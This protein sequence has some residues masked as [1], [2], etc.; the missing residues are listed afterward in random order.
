MDDVPTRVIWAPPTEPLALEATTMVA[1]AVQAMEQLR[2]WA[3]TSELRALPEVQAILTAPDEIRRACILAAAAFEERLADTLLALI[4]RKRAGLSVAD[5]EAILPPL[6]RSS[7]HQQRARAHSRLWLLMGQVAATWSA[8]DDDGRERLRGQLVRVASETGNEELATRLRK[9]AGTG[10]GV[11][12]TLIPANDQACAALQAAIAASPEPDSSRTALIGLL[13]S[14]PA[15]GKAGKKWA[16]AAAAVYEAMNDPVALGAVLLDALLDAPDAVEFEHEAA[17]FRFGTRR[18]QYLEWRNT[19]VASAVPALAGMIA[20]GACDGAALLPR[21]RKL[22]LKA[23]TSVDGVPRSIKLA[24]ACVSALAD[25]GLSASVTEL[26]RID[27]GTRHGSL[28]KQVRTAIGNLATAQGL[29]RDELLERSVEDHGL[30][31]DGTK[32]ASLANGWTAMLATSARTAE[33]SYAGPDGKARKAP[34]TNVKQASADILKAVR[35]DLKAVRETIGN[36]RARLDALLSSG[37]SW[38]LATWRELYLDHPVTGR[39]ARALIWTFRAGDI[40]STGIPVDVPDADGGAAA[41]IAVLASDGELARVPD[42]A[43]VRLWHPVGASADEVRAWRRLLVDRQT[44]QPVKQ[45]FREV[46][47]LAP[48]EEAT[49]DYS[50]RFAG[51]V[52]RQVQARALMKGRGWAP[53]PLAW[54]DDGID[55][56]VARREYPLPGV[57]QTLR[58]EFFFDYTGND[59][60]S[61]DLY[62]Y[63]ASDQVRFFGA[64]TGEAVPLAEVPPLVFTE[65]MRDVD[66]FIGVTSI[67]NDPEWQDHG[68]GRRFGDT[69][70][71]RWGFGELGASAE[72]RRETL[73][74]LV[75]MLAIADRCTLEDRFLVVRGDLR[76]YRIHLGSGNI[77]MSPNDQYLCIVQ[78]RSSQADKVFLPFDDDRVLSLILSKAFL[79]AADTAITDPTITRQIGTT[80]SHLR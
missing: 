50:N 6:A 40:E 30:A 32:A 71:Q 59:D 80:S 66:L 19:P 56:G 34:P 29:S 57:A 73:A 74:R 58:A 51:H 1:A 76:T 24:N 79:L 10:E 15:S 21:L 3:P 26:L 67:G 72:V 70:W 27:R 46:Y 13:T 4:A 68:E 64:A 7:D 33:I 35:Q 53:V 16:A 9:I 60:M 42:G 14:F 38:E 28:L 2:R 55:Q 31:A 18:G 49:R 39:A 23:I 75:P 77:L 52:F 11:P 65:A 37:R 45:A 54:W 36:E 5:I 43:E 44:V 47:V 8:A 25:A 48:A 41:G 17:G 62:T 69:Y 78:A 20:S 22:A 63:V 61:G 12:I